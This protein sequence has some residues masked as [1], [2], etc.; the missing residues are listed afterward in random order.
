MFPGSCTWETSVQ[1]LLQVRPAQVASVPTLCATAPH[2]DLG[3]P[4]QQRPCCRW[5]QPP[6]CSTM[7]PSFLPGTLCSAVAVQVR[8]NSLPVPSPHATG[9]SMGMN[10]TYRCTAS[11]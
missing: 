9:C 3:T 4:A 2:A 11:Q 7:F 6:A 1:P 8:A 5:Q 10:S